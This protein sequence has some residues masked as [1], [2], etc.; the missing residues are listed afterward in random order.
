M[1]YRDARGCAGSEIEADT[2]GS[3]IDADEMHEAA[4]LVALRHRLTGI[5]HAAINHRRLHRPTQDQPTGQWAHGEGQRQAD[6]D[7]AT[8]A[9]RSFCGGGRLFHAECDIA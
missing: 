9:V 3:K 8:P 2:G 6:G 7:A 4:A 1:M 5:N